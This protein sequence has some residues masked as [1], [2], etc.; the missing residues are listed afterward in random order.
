[1]RASKELTEAEVLTSTT[2]LG[3]SF[4]VLRLLLTLKLWK[5]GRSTC[6]KAGFAAFTGVWALIGREP[7]VSDGLATKSRSSVEGIPVVK[8]ML[9]RCRPFVGEAIY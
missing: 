3:S 9:E 2:G 8:Q 1:M 4:D 7:R 6:C 5:A